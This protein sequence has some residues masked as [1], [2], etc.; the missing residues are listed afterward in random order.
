[1]NLQDYLPVPS[2]PIH[3]HKVIF[4]AA[5]ENKLSLYS[6]IPPIPDKRGLN[7]IPSGPFKNPIVYRVFERMSSHD[8]R[9]LKQFMLELNSKEDPEERL[10]FL[11][12]SPQ[13]RS[14]KLLREERLEEG[15]KLLRIDPSEC[16]ALAFYPTIFVSRFIPPLEY[17]KKHRL[18]KLGFDKN[19]VAEAVPLFQ[20]NGLMRRPSP[21]SILNVMLLKQE[22]TKWV[23][24]NRL[25][26][27][28]EGRRKQ[29]DKSNKSK[30]IISVFWRA[31][32]F[33]KKRNDGEDPNYREVWDAV[34][35][36]WYNKE[37][38]STYKDQLFPDLDYDIDEIIIDIERSDIANASV[39][40]YI[41]RSE[42]KGSYLLAS[43]PAKLSKLKKTLPPSRDFTGF[44]RT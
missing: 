26:R 44:K 34:Y 23:D 16:G 40:W 35:E 9:I 13:I 8:E 20:K 21:V 24:K 3:Y 25:L 5:S 11:D 18:N 43:L 4:L 38:E 37:N 29:K 32:C 17:L 39:T 10:A 7:D 15:P 30:E 2:I 14:G 42:T 1:M 31:F 36:E 27:K 28:N 12:K 6:S 22:A 19:R 33:L 41:K